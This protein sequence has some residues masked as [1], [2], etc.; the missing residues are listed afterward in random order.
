MAT[1]LAA[2]A[3]KIRMAVDLRLPDKQVRRTVR[4]VEMVLPRRHV[5]P[6]LTYEGSAYAEN[7]VD[8]AAL[9]H[10]REGSVCV[11]DVGANVGDSALLILGRTPSA[12]VVCVEP[13]PAWLEYLNLNV[14]HRPNIAIEASV[15]L[16][17]DDPAVG[18]LTMVHHSIGTSQ[19]ERGGEGDQVD[20]ITVEELRR[21][22]P[23]LSGVRLVKTDTDGW[24]VMLVPEFAATFQGSRPVI[25]FEFDPRPTK[26]ATPHLDPD[27]MW[28]R[29]A[30]LGYVDALVW[31]NG[32]HVLGA[33]PVDSMVEK[34]RVLDQPEEQRGYVFW[35][36]AVAH[37]DDAVV[38]AV[39]ANMAGGA[40]L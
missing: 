40:L 37:L 27:D 15:L 31:D 17:A 35:D 6:H 26:V 7:L 23:Q 3:G 39:H 38:R 18:P 29:L 14:S 22:H 32:G 20:G 9:L 4:G 5:L 25:F 11:L 8:L 2:F 21:R 30:D 10:E 19:V 28:R 12:D 1:S 16:A 33:A 13:D 24:D 36:V 34:S